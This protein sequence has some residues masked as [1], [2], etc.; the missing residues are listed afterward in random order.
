M[1]KRT[2]KRALAEVAWNDLFEF[3]IGTRWRRDQVLERLGLTP[4][5]AKALHSLDVDKGKRMRSLAQEWGTDPS[6][7]TWVVNRLVRK[8]LAKRASLASDRRVTL[9]L[10]TPRGAESRAELL[11]AFQEPPT[12]LLS[13]DR[14]ELQTLS[15]LLRKVRAEVRPGERRE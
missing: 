11:R 12:E 14:D 13:L 3:F 4:N 2:T 1:T 7:A 15:Q 9:V 8:R 6:N 10:L 5:D